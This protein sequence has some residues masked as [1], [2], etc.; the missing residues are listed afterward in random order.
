MG[1]RAGALAFLEELR[2]D[3]VITLSRKMQG[4]VFKSIRNKVYEKK[5]DQRELIKVAQRNFRKY[6]A[7]RDWGWFVIIQK[8]RPLIGMPDPTEELRI[9]EEKAQ[10]TYGVYKENLDKKERLLQ[11][12]VDIETDKKALLK[13]IDSEQGNMSQYHERLAKIGSEKGSLEGELVVWQDKLVKTEQNRVNAGNDKKDLELESVSVKKDIGDVEMVIQKLDQEKTNRDHNIK[14]LN[15]EIGNQDE[16][17]N[18]L[19]KEKK[20][21][22]DNAAKAAEDLQVAADKVEH[23]NK[24]KQKLESTLD[25]LEGSVEKEKRARG[26]LEKEKRKIEGELKIMQETVSE[27]E[28]SRKEL[29][30]QVGRKDNDMIGYNA[31]LDDEQALVS[32]VQKGIKELQGRVEQTEEELEAERQARAKAERQRSDLAREFESL[33]ERLNEASGA[34]A[35]QIELNKKRDSEV[36]WL[37]KDAEEAAIQ[38]DATVIGMKKKQQDSVAEISEQIDQLSKMKAKYFFP[39]VFLHNC[40]LIY[41]VDQ[42]KSKI[43]VEVSE[44]RAA[45]DKVAR[46]KASAEKSYRSLVAVLNDQNK[47]VEESNLNLGDIEAGKRRI[48]AE[49]ADLLRVLQELQSNANLLLKT[50]VALVSSLDEM[51]AIADNEATERVGLLGKFRNLEH[52]FDGLKAFF[53]EEAGGYEN[54]CRLVL[55]AQGDADM[56]RQKYEIDG[57]GKAE[58]LEMARLKLQARLSESQGMIEQMQMKLVQLEKA[59]TKL[60]SETGDMAI[61][62]DQAQVLMQ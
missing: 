5:R 4:Q 53:D 60:Q 7:L 36:T 31:K 3:I 6:M 48:T 28:R 39:S 37:R 18:K 14:S 46:S 54:A 16:V 27:I 19:N 45:T 52:E 21:I 11:E 44:V 62:L 34:T 40:F 20:H 35:A 25:E 26:N 9:L 42:D 57:I 1:F 22:S 50:K 33:G 32:K 29:E 8:T 55:K 30:A 10:A 59:K 38:R 13:T 17:I 47:K 49:N 2:D 23:L 58:E 43:I 15:D 24:V 56:Y 12:N 61:Q 51:K 41:R